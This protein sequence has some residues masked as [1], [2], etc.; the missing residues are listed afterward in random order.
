MKKK[1]VVVIFW[2]A[3]SMASCRKYSLF[4]KTNLSPAHISQDLVSNNEE[5]IDTAYAFIQN[6][7][8]SYQQTIQ[9]YNVNASFYDSFALINNDKIAANYYLS[10][11]RELLVE[12]FKSTENAFSIYGSIYPVQVYI[13]RGMDPSIGMTLKGS[14][15]HY[16]TQYDNR[17]VGFDVTQNDNIVFDGMRPGGFEIIYREKFMG[18]DT[19]QLLWL[20]GFKLIGINESKDTTTIREFPLNGISL[21]SGS[22][23]LSKYSNRARQIGAHFA[24]DQIQTL[25]SKSEYFR[26]ALANDKL[27]PFANEILIK[28]K[29][30]SENATYDY[31]S[32]HFLQDKRILK[33]KIDSFNITLT[34]DK[35]FA[36]MEPKL[37]IGTLFWFYKDYGGFESQW[38]L[39]NLIFVV[40]MLIF[41][42]TGI[43]EKIREPL[44]KGALTLASLGINIWCLSQ[45]PKGME[46]YYWLIHF[47]FTLL[48]YILLAHLK[49]VGPKMKLRFDFSTT[50]VSEV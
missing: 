45:R 12:I 37:R 24:N 33:S 28:I 1:H 4:S 7:I 35:M 17:A 23:D 42:L 8:Q 48:T 50:K 22:T 2:L 5:K 41:L 47:T 27:K 3:I 40:L 38:I 32:S 36:E 10:T 43:T 16:L 15:E 25:W 6:I 9:N 14:F 39:A 44:T 30:S 20:K 11:S 31:D 21:I 46:F 18:L 13:Y 34:I 29:H 49:R 19:N 26:T